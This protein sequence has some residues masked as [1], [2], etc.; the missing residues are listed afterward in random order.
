MPVVHPGLDDRDSLLGGAQRGHG[1]AYRE[2]LDVDSD[3]VAAI[4]T[5]CSVNDPRC[6][7]QMDSRAAYYG[8]LIAGRSLPVS[9]IERHLEQE[10]PP[11]R[12][13]ERTGTELAVDVLLDATLRGYEPAREVMRRYT[14]TGAH[15]TRVVLDLVRAGDDANDMADPIR[16]RFGDDDSMYQGL[17]DAGIYEGAYDWADEPLSTW[18]ATHERIA[19]ASGR[20][21]AEAESDREERRRSKAEAKAERQSTGKPTKDPPLHDLTTEALLDMSEGGGRYMAFRALGHVE[22]D[23][24]Y[25]VAVSNALSG[26]ARRQDAAIRALGAHGHDVLLDFAP[27]MVTLGRNVE[28]DAIEYTSPQFAAYLALQKLTSP[29]AV[30]AARGW[31]TTDNPLGHVG[32]LV[33]ANAGEPRDLALVN[34]AYAWLNIDDVYLATAVVDAIREQKRTPC[35]NVVREIFKD[36]AYDHL[37]RRCVETLLALDPTFASS[38]DLQDCLWD[39]SWLVRPLAAEALV[40]DPLVEQRLQDVDELRGDA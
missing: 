9:D 24:D 26:P 40:G 10:T 5:E 6:D 14:L 35:L 34:D 39:S 2:L 33:L 29:A 20:I 19:A 28:P 31:V 22:H 7:Q 15:W 13:F 36:S 17:Y 3:H 38:P 8:S 11:T 18:A 32:W 1:W 27:A 23:L 37:R 4:L 30:E 16:E 25:G 12:P 21:V